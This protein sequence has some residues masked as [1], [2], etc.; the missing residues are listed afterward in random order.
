MCNF[1]LEFD[2]ISSL[3]PNYEIDSYKWFKENEVLDNIKPDSLAKWFYQE[4][5]KK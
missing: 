3:K 2:D 5:L 1:I 4:Y